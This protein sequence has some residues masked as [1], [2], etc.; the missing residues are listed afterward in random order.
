MSNRSLFPA[1]SLTVPLPDHPQQ[2]QLPAFSTHPRP[3]QDLLSRGF[4]PER[5]GGGEPQSWA[6]R[7]GL[8][9]SRLVVTRLDAP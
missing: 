1:P 5:W 9:T 4:K 6:E 2:A 8:L 3:A 7:K